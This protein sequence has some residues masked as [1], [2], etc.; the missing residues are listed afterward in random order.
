MAR[1]VGD[2]TA[3]LS[4]VINE[5]EGLVEF[6]AGETTRKALKQAQRDLA[7]R[8]GIALVE[9]PWAHVDALLREAHQRAA[10]PTR[11]PD[12]QR[13]RQLIAPASRPEPVPSPIDALLDRAS[14]E[15]DPA[16]LAASAEALREPET[17]GWV[18]PYPWLEAALEEVSAAR[19]SLVVISPVQQEERVREAAEKAMEA[20]FEPAERRALFASRFEETAYLLAKRGRGPIAR[21]ALAAAIATRA[22][23]RIAEVPLLAEIARRSLALAFEAQAAKAKEEAQSSLIVTPAQALAEQRARARRR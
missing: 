14:V 7:A 15:A 3:T 4:A 1:R 13:A 17:A 2:G 23:R 6:H 20:L 19:S 8:A 18:L 11:F 22:G 12:V 5:N 10:D 21:A 16:A 9:A